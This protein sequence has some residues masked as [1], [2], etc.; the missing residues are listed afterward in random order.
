[1]AYEFELSDVLLAG[2]AAIASKPE[3]YVYTNQEGEVAGVAQG[4]DQISCRYVHTVKSETGNDLVR[5]CY[6]G[7]VLNRLGWR[8]VDLDRMSGYI[9]EYYDHLDIGEKISPLALEFL[10]NVQA[11]QDAG[12][13]WR[14]AHD[15]ALSELG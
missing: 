5:G 4:G 13:P 11:K 14:K 7:D 9:E 8:L 3:G 15:E 6:A 1:M 10:S 12:I 2:E